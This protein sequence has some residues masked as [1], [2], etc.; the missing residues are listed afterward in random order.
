MFSMSI[1]GRISKPIKEETY[2]F[3]PVLLINLFRADRSSLGFHFLSKRGEN[4]NC[5]QWRITDFIRSNPVV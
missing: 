5:S 2:S 1:M 3:R 4:K